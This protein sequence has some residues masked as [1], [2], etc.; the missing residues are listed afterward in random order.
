MK[1][2]K[3]FS[4]PLLLAATIIGNGAQAQTVRHS[5]VSVSSAVRSNAF[6]GSTGA[7]VAFFDQSVSHPLMD[8]IGSTRSSLDIEIYEMTDPDV[9][10]AL[11]AAL[12]RGVRMRIVHE[13]APLGGT[14][15]LFAAPSPRD[16]ADCPD[17]RSLVSEVKA[18]GGQFVPFAT[19]ALCGQ[20]G[21]RCFE[22]GKLV[23]SDRSQ[24][25][26]STGNFDSTNLCNIA[27]SPARC[28]RDY[29]VVTRDGEVVSTLQ[30]VFDQD[31]LGTAYDLRSMITPS[32]ETKLTVSPFSLEPLVA[33]IKSARQSI[34]VQNQYLKEPTINS[35]LAEAARAGVRVT[36]MTESACAFGTPKPSAVTAWTRVYSDFDSAGIK[37]RIFN[38]SIRIDGIPGY[39]HAKAIVVDSTRAWVGSVN[40]ST[41]AASNNREFGLFFEDAGSVHS[42]V[43]LMDQDFSDSRAESWQQSLTCTKD[44]RSSSS[45]AGPITVTD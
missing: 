12:A 31:V 7:D 8:L 4:L 32:V 45:A 1:L 22:H 41:T 5:A 18:A 9:R 40:G 23:I 14:C 16:S 42:L 26:V 10:S 11:R 21:S 33:F 15:P 43:A 36:V 27:R 3:S 29:S 17:Q 6:V 38:S 24:V 39:L 34:R 2:A 44:V 28:N 13:P 35:A 25:L 37:S 30:H 20:I 19:S